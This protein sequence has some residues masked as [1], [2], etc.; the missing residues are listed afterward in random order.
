M[1]PTT[2]RDF[3]KVAAQRMTTAEVMLRDDTVRFPSLSASE[4]PL[5]PVAGAQ[6]RTRQIQSCGV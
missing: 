2:T 6:A 4:G 3:Q 5:V 1:P